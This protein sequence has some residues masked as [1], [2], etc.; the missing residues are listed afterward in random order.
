M[1]NYTTQTLVAERDAL[2]QKLKEAKADIEGVLDMAEGRDIAPVKTASDAFRT[3]GSAMDYVTSQKIKVSSERDDL[4]RQLG[5]ITL[6]L[7]EVQHFPEGNPETDTM[8]SRIKAADYRINT[9]EFLI[10]ADDLL[11]LARNAERRG[12]SGDFIKAASDFRAAIKAE[13]EKD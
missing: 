4:A 8:V 1:S 9:L 11:T 10:D 3:I 5:E 13:T 6:A 12:P 2:T 7:G